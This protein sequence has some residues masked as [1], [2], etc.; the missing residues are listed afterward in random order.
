MSGLWWACSHTFKEKLD[1]NRHWIGK[2]NQNMCTKF[3]VRRKYQGNMI[4]LSLNDIIL[5]KSPINVPPFWMRNWQQKLSL[6]QI[7]LISSV[8]ISPQEMNLTLI[9]IILSNIPTLILPTVLNYDTL[10]LIQ[11]H[12]PLF[13]YLFLKHIC[14]YL[15]NIKQEIKQREFHTSFK[16]TRF[17]NIRIPINTQQFILLFF[18]EVGYWLIDLKA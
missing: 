14:W 15:L 2:K 16:H 4:S 18:G 1:K 17:F 8:Y 5:H 3:T 10:L 9:L 12:I 11:F 7:L 6:Y 13:W